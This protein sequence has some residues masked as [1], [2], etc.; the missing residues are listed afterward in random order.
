MSESIEKLIIGVWAPVA[1]N[2]QETFD[3]R[4]DGTVRMALFGGLLHMGG[5][6]RFIAPEVIEINW[7]ASPSAEAKDVIGAVNK[8]LDH[9][10]SPAGVRI[11]QQTVMRVQVTGDEL[12]TLQLEKGRVGHFRRVHSTQEDENI[13]R[14]NH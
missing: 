8:K 2:P 12:Q 3:Y 1:G 11:V 4:A 7:Q 6:Y 5:R 9:E 10:S 13:S 14:P